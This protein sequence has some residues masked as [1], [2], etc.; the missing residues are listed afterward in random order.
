MGRVSDARERILAAALELIWEQSYHS[1]GVDA[2]CKRAGV[3]K[4]TFYHFFP[5]KAYL[6]A[7]A[8]HQHWQEYKPLLD[9]I[10]SPTVA[11]LARLDAYFNKVYEFQSER[12]HL[13]GFV[14]G[15]PYFDLGIEVATLDKEIL[16]QVRCVID[17][18][19]RYFASAV[20]DAVAQE[21]IAATDTDTSARRLLHYFEGTLMNARIHNDPEL[22]RDLPEGARQLLGVTSVNR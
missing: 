17:L 6:S 13:S 4:G 18:Y 16:V 12:K 8:I 10:F 3:R 9:S 5:S 7:A 14:C 11:P 19:F 21:V 22:L 2:I 15:C 20:R 1:V